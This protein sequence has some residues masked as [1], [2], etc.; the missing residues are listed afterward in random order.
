MHIID[1]AQP[2]LRL[3]L[4]PSGIY[5]L[6]E[7]SSVGLT[8]RELL[9]RKIPYE[10]GQAS[11]KNLA[12]AQ[13]TDQKIGMLKLLFHTATLQTRINGRP[14]GRGHFAGGGRSIDVLV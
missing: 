6:P 3:D 7:I 13:M 12:R 1:P 8:E 14:R 10:V 5:T 9:A 4:V 2:P 11:F